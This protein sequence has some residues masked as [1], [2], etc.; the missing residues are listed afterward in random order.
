VFTNAAT[1]E[2]NP[3]AFLPGSGLKSPLK[4]PPNPD[5]GNSGGGLLL[6]SR[7]GLLLPFLKV[8]NLLN[9]FTPTVPKCE[10]YPSLIF[11]LLVVFYW[12]L[13]SPA[14]APVVVLISWLVM[15]NIF[16]MVIF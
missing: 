6:F 5:G 4:P 1:F 2:S 7:G 15:L 16:G 11:T 13:L 9:G 12:K 14:I 10:K 8:P 3:L